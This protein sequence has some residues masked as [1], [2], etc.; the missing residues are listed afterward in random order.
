MAVTKEGLNRATLARQ[1][2]LER[3]DGD[4]REV[5]GQVLALQ[6]QESAS[7][8]LALWN[9]MEG[10]DPER[11]DRAF[12]EASVVKGSVMRITLHAVRAEDYDTMHAAMQTTLRGSR[13]NDRRFKGTGLTS[14]QADALVPELLA[15]LTDDV[16]TTDDIL[17]FLDEHVDGDPKFVWW[18]LR[19]YA[20]IRH[21]P[22]GP[23][24]S[25]GPRPSYL[26]GSHEPRPPDDPTALAELVRR[27]LCAFG[28][29]TV[30]DAGQFLLVQ[31]NRIRAALD[32]IADQVVDLAG[33][34]DSR[35][36]DVPD[37]LR[38]DDDTPAPPRLL[39]M[40]D[41]ILFAH[42]DRSRMI[43]PDLRPLVIRRNGDSLPTLLVDGRVAG[44][45]RGTEDGRIEAT[46]LRPITE[47]A[48]A[49]LAD[50]ATSL[51]VLLAGRTP[52]PYRR[53]HPWWDKLPP[54]ETRVLP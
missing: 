4:L 9:R 21:A 47:E 38:P 36:L 43:P 24:W 34:G 37:G 40:W 50:E 30:A 15:F 54:G 16:H 42:H 8:Y 28:P 11:L 29:A 12:T 3:R 31:R 53:Y 13:L 5:L 23:P 35:L 39:G 33:P 22:T 48:W 52:Q 46:A 14:D 20:P 2:L 27:Y 6:A 25:F 19:T 10:F 1:C 41:S 45:W 18:A 26:A 7:P 44:V 49:G 17:A 51:A 32:L